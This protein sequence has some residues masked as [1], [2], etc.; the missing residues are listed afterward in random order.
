MLK[1]QNV[2]LDKVFHIELTATLWTYKRCSKN[3]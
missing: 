2:C 1:A 3:N